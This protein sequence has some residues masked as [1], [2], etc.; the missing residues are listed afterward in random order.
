[1]YLVP[2]CVFST[3]ICGF[4]NGS[5]GEVVKFDEEDAFKEQKVYYGIKDDDKEEEGKREQ[6]D[7]DKQKA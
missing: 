3:V 5:L 6:N 7:A 2:G 1:M 4:I